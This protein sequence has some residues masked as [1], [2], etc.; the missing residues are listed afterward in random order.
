MGRTGPPELA[1]EKQP[2]HGHSDR[3]A[4]FLLSALLSLELSLQQ[5]LHTL[6]LALMQAA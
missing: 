6:P 3:A 5:W 2:L 1:K 4:A